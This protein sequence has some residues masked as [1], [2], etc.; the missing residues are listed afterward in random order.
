[1]LAINFPEETA[2][3]TA[4]IDP[5]EYENNRDGIHVSK[6]VNCKYYLAYVTSDFRIVRSVDNAVI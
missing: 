5:S 3:R 6:T 4:T 2:R 1:M